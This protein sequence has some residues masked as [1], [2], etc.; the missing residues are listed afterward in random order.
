MVDFQRGSPDV[1]SRAPNAFAGPNPEVGYA[2]AFD[3]H[4]R[5][6]PAPECS[7]SLKLH[8]A[9]K[10]YSSLRKIVSADLKK[11]SVSHP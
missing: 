2:F 1:T 5:E 9:K 7:F 11:T 3:S 8:S 10:P 4:V 6:A